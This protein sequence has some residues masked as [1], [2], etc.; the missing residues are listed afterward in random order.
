MDT[1]TYLRDKSGSA[2]L[3]DRNSLHLQKQNECKR[4]GRGRVVG[5]KAL[6]SWHVRSLLWHYHAW[7]RECGYNWSLLALE[8]IILC[9]G[10]SR[11]SFLHSGSF[12]EPG[13]GRT[14]K[15]LS[16]RGEEVCAEKGEQVGNEVSF[17]LHDSNLGPS[18]KALWGL[19][20]NEGWVG[21]GQ[22]P[23]N[24]CIAVCSPSSI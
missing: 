14:P 4:D 15:G 8:C 9:E 24:V 22:A 6:G 13:K 2:Y 1:H 19:E 18:P 11:K 21:W 3:H 23:L 12:R 10:H 20:V 5:K 16:A 7:Q 17:S